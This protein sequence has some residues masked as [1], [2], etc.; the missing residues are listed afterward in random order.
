[1]GTPGLPS[2]SLLAF[3]SLSSCHPV[4]CY[5]FLGE[6][7]QG[8]CVER[9]AA[10]DFLGLAGRGSLI[11]PGAWAPA[12]AGGMSHSLQAS[13]PMVPVKVENITLNAFA[14][15]VQGLKVETDPGRLS[16]AYRGHRGPHRGW[17]TALS[18]SLALP[19]DQPQAHGLCFSLLFCLFKE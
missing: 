11:P 13:G 6:A 8:N 4:K 16:Q 2:T 1:M 3:S 18:S 17:V 15:W 12:Q 14:H 19:C 5:C 7:S 10:A 9:Q